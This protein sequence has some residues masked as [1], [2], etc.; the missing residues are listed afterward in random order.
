MV[1]G[2]ENVLSDHVC[3]GCITIMTAEST[4]SRLLLYRYNNIYYFKNSREIFPAFT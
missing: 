4:K 1:G 3:I 2:R